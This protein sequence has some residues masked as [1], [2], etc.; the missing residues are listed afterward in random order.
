VHLDHHNC[1]EALALKGPGEGVQ[2]LSQKLIS[3]RGVKY[4]KLTL[5]TTGQ[6]I[7]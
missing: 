1:L 3:T 5:A 2:K 6:D 7:V 4:G